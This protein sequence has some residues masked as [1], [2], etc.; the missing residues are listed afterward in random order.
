MQRAR[1][2]AVAVLAG[3][4]SFLICLWSARAA[5]FGFLPRAETDRWLVATAFAT[6]VATLVGAAAARWAGSEGRPGSFPPDNRSPEM[7][8]P[9]GTDGQA[10]R[11]GATA[12]DAAQVTQV[13]GHRGRGHAAPRER[14][15][16]VTQRATASGRSRVTQ[17]GGND[18]TAGPE[19]GDR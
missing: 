17:V 8:D 11:Q 1:R 18:G 7:P 6:T 5:P 3:A 15:G 4:G 14:P 10:V 13:A 9:P 19:R 12:S 16:R 2:W